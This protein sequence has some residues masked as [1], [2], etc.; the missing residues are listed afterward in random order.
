MSDSA[1]TAVPLDKGPR[2]IPS[3]ATVALGLAAGPV[4]ALGFTRFAYALLLPAM[5]SD[6]HWSFAASGG[7]TTANAVGYVIGCL[8]AA[9]LARRFGE[10]GIFVAGMAVS[11]AALLL[12]APSG[13]YTILTIVRFVGG[14]STSVVFVIGSAA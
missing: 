10:R 4:V 11:A 12:S 14:L 5:R 13:D 6:L 8:T 9:A 2:R 7:I 3:A 1:S